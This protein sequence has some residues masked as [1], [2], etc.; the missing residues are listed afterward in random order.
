MLEKVLRRGI[1]QRACSIQATGLVI[2][3]QN[4]MLNPQCK[5]INGASLGERFSNFVSQVFTF[6][7]I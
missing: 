3:L 6:L 4:C 7:V 5:V 2:Y 1:L